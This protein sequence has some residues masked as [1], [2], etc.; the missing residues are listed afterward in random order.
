MKVRITLHRS[1][2][3][4]EIE[5]EN[6]DELIEN[7]KGFPEWLE[8][9]DGMIVAS[10]SGISEKEVLKG[11]VENTPDG[12]LITVSREKL[13]DREAVGL[14]LYATEPNGLKPKELSRLLNLSG[15]L[16]VGFASRLS[17]LKREGLAYKEGEAYRLT[18]S[19]KKWIEKLISSF[20]SGG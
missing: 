8:V 1:Y 2:G 16:S 6:F 19:G 4:I 14:L 13:T 3:N 20:K 5:G 12:P 15:F 11:I 17:E 9:I 7:L 18:V 10:S